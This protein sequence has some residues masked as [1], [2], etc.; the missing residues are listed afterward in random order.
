MK[1][2]PIT[3]MGVGDITIDRDQ[4]EMIFQNVAETLRS[5]DI[6]YGNTDQTYSDLGYPVLGHGPNSESKNFKALPYAGFD[7]ISLANNHTLDWGEENLLD[8]LK[9]FKEGGMPYA[10]AGKNIEEARAPV[11]L[12]RKGTKVGF[13]AYSMVY[14]KGYGATETKPGLAAIRV[15]T[16]YEQVDHHPG[17]PP[18][19]VTIAYPEDRKMMEED[20]AKL[21]KQVDIVVIAMHWG[22]HITP[23]VI[24]M[25]CMELGR[26]AIDAGADLVLGTHTHIL[27]GVEMYKGK[28]IFYSTGNFAIET[29]PATLRKAPGSV[30][31]ITQIL[32]RYGCKPDP[33]CPT[34]FCPHE[35]RTTMIVKALIEDGKIKKLTYIPCYINKY[36]EPE[37]VKQN[38]PRGQ[39]VYNY[40]Q[41]VSRSE[42]LSVHFAWDGDEVS[43]LP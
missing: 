31:A 5:A 13:L 7:V 26:A 22:I 43:V 10:G 34:F 33:E 28:A 41:D 6:A 42:N 37:I 11:I 2:E 36:S 35:A 8:T 14:T 15:W 3:L 40:V 29:G 1:K 20:I 4:P 32:A 24:P 27:K 23:R 18:R 12:E 38:D 19:I 9:R 25:Y 39:E 21:K 17:T 16:I 30:Q